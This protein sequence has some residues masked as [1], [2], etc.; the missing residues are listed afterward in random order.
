MGRHRRGFGSGGV[1]LNSPL[2]WQRPQLKRSKKLM[3]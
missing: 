3:H 2:N 1:F